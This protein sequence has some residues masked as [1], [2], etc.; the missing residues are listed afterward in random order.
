MG[1]LQGEPPEGT[2]LRPYPSHRFAAGPSHS[3]AM[4]GYA[5]RRLSLKS[6]TSFRKMIF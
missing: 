2:D 3:R 4:G 6:T 1:A 5:F